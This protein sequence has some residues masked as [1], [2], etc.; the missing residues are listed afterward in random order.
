MRFPPGFS[1]SLFQD[2][3]KVA[4]SGCQGIFITRSTEYPS[5]FGIVKHADLIVGPWETRPEK[6]IDRSDSYPIK[7]EAEKMELIVLFMT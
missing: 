3:L 4:A 1:F 5:G 2:L 7:R 6:T